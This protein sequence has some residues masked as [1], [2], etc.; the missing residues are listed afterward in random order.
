MNAATSAPEITSLEQAREVVASLFIENRLLRQKLDAFIRHYFGGR[1][2]EGL[3]AKQLQ[4]A[5]LGL[6]LT[7]AA[8]EEPQAQ[9][10]VAAA[11]PRRKGSSHPVRRVLDS[12][13]LETRETVIEPEEVKAQPEGWRKI[14]EERT[15]LLDYEPGKLIKQ[16]IVR[17]RYVKN[18]EFALAPLPPQP[19]EQSMA[20]AGLLAH[21]V[22][23][24][25]EH[26]TPL[27][28]LE[29]IFSHE[30]GVELSRKTMGDW[31]YQ[32]AELVKPVYQAIGEALQKST[33]L[34]ADETPIRCL[35]PDVKGK[36]VMAYLWIYGKPKGDVFFDW[37]L[38]RSRE[39]PAKF[40]KEFK[41][42]L[43]T[44]AWSAYERLAK[45]R[46]GDIILAGCLAHGR[47]GFKDA[48]AENKVAAWFVKQMALLY[49][50]EQDLRRGKAGPQLRAAVRQH[51]SAPVMAR[52][53]KGMEIVRR[54]SLPQ[55]LLGKAI[56]YMLV[57]WESFT[58]FLTDGRLEIDN[59]L[60][61]NAIRPTAIGKKNWL[62]IGAPEA[63]QRSAIIYTLLG[64]CRRQGINP[65]EYFRDLI[66]RLPAAKIT[67]IKQFVP[68]AWL[69]AHNQSQRSSKA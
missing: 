48:I 64:C 30:H 43:Q 61:E 3:D 49:A 14:S 60:I 32:I 15:T 13:K 33:Y 26:H 44:D 19:I 56:D 10:P 41:G 12:D 35:D 42:T 36:S 11:Q 69:K 66:T 24:K 40:L 55:G 17:P 63:G 53:R 6:E 58:R 25:F 22:V 1:R 38:E 57:R 23:T 5:L 8:I 2:N 39:G 67:E 31:V 4:M 16:V 21:V 20:G 37:R 47:R 34:Q 68:S 27:Y 46:N 7:T 51:Q 62:F 65:Y 45:E 29:R 9:A 54:K 59:N 52:L 28:R 18:E 50:V